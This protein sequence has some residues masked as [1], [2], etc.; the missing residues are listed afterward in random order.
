[1][2]IQRLGNILEIIA[3]PEPKVKSKE[4]II[5]SVDELYDII[6]DIKQHKENMYTIKI[7]YRIK[8][9]Y[10]IPFILTKN[11]D[12]VKLT[13]VNDMNEPCIE[14]QF[15]DEYIYLEDYYL[16]GHKRCPKIYHSDFF[17]FLNNYYLH[18]NFQ[19]S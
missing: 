9:D 12:M 3:K 4:P 8:G 14:I 6:Q 19:V 13:I 7:L 10:V 1:M 18:L 2:Y 16:H 5:D 11:T 15:R 17:M